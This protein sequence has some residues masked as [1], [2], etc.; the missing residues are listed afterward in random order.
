MKQQYIVDETGKKTAVVLSIKDYARLLEDLHDLQVAAER[1][2]DSTVPLYKLKSKL[3]AD[4][5]YI[6][7]RHEAYRAL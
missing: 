7:H 3:R 1:R 5:I 6:S 2:E 4:G